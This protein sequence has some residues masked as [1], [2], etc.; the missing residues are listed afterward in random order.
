M[1]KLEETLSQLLKR[2]FGEGSFDKPTYF[3]FLNSRLHS[4]IE[5]TYRKL[6]GQL[7]NYP[8]SFR[9]FDIELPHLIVELDEA[10]HFNRYR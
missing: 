10:Q 8:V 1:P 2:E 5:S 7:D 9:G 6:N 4:E 3:D